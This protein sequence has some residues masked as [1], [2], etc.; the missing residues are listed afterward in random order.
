MKSVLLICTQKSMDRPLRR[1]LTHL[2]KILPDH[3]DL[4]A[5]QPPSSAPPDLADRLQIFCQPDYVP[6]ENFENSQPVGSAALKSCNP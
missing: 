6:P 5:N 1:S 2:A 4:L 3:W